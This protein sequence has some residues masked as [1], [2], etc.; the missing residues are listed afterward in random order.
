MLQQ[1]GGDYQ[2]FWGITRN[3]QIIITLNG[4]GLCDQKSTELSCVQTLRQDRSEGE[5]KSL[6]S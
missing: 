3:V 6:R 1:F 2:V 5:R 4:N